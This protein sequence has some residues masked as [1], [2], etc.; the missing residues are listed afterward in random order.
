[1]HIPTEDEDCYSLVEW[2]EAK[3]LRFSHIPQETFTRSW[4]IKMKNKK[5]G[6]RK[7]VPD[8]IIVHEGKLCFIE[9]K[10]AVHRLS[11]FTD[12]QREWLKALGKVPGVTAAVCYGLDEAISTLERFLKV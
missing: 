4:G 5:K 10:R 12:E 3:R 2:M 9:M 8:Y 7:G 11:H 1:M 6:V